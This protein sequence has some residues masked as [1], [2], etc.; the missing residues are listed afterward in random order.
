M[1][2]APRVSR[3][4]Q[5]LDELGVHVDAQLFD[6]AFT[7]RSWAYENGGAESNERLEFLGDAVLQ[8]VVT[9]HIFRT[10][11]DMAEGHMAK[12]RASVVSSRALARV[13]TELELGEHIKLGKGEIATGGQAKSSIL[14]D[15]M[16]AVIGAV[17]ISGGSEASGVFVHAVF[18]P[19]ILLSEE[20]G[21]YTDFKTALQELC[22]ARGWGPPLYEITGSGP[23]HQRVF[24]AVAIVGGNRVSSGTAP[25]KKTAE[26]RAATLAHRALAELPHA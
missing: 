12:L 14:A 19:L 21:S 18:D 4:V 13:A 6:L 9:E 22:A 10:Y 25:S 11:P 1:A 26:Q 17:H 15:T 2:P 8:I 20:D 16:E 23:D 7:H 3:L 24:T 5:E